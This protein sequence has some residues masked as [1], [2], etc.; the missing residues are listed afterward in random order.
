M[1]VLLFPALHPPLCQCSEAR[2]WVQG[3]SGGGCD[4]T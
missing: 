4:C 3:I 2:P 1:K